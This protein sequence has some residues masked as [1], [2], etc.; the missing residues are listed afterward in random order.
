MEYWKNIK[1]FENVY[2]ISSLGRVKS[3]ARKVMRSNGVSM[4][5]KERILKTCL[6]STGYE[7]AVLQN[8]L[9]TKHFAVH[10]LVALAFIPNPENKEQVNH[11]DGV[12][13]NNTVS[14]LEWATRSENEK[15]A[16][17]IGLKNWSGENASRAKLKE[18]QVL[19][20]RQ[21]ELNLSQRKLAEK[22]NVSRSTI[23]SILN[24]KNWQHL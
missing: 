7:H 5:I 18:K 24:R 17:R 22:Y 3:L 11:K 12:K 20:I 1:G 10:R 13:T 15:H 2:Q 8:G 23:R 6:T 16:H 9:K 4:N 21:N 14:N 19:Q